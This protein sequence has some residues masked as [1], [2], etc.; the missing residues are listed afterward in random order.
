MGG[1]PGRCRRAQLIEHKVAACLLCMVELPLRNAK[2]SRTGAACAQ[3][4]TGHGVQ[5]CVGRANFAPGEEGGR[6]GGL[7][8][9][10][11]SGLLA[12]KATY[13]NKEFLEVGR[14]FYVLVLAFLAA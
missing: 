6:G 7:A 8:K 2:D 11:R 3:A 5:L 12:L 14:P 1:A 13:C 4:P 10:R 9:W